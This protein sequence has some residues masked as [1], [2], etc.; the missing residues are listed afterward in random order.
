MPPEIKTS[1]ISIFKK[2]V[3]KNKIILTQLFHTKKY[4]GKISAGENKKILEGQMCYGRPH[5]F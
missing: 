2:S 1:F 4:F 3:L 5:N